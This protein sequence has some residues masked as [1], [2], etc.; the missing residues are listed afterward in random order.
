MSAMVLRRTTVARGLC[1]V[2][3]RVGGGGFWVMRKPRVHIKDEPAQ[4]DE[5]AG[6]SDCLRAKHGPNIVLCTEV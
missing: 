6:K 1:G 3:R 4:E 5:Q 2:R